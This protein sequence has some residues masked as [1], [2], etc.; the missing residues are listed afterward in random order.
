MQITSEQ[1]FSQ[2]SIEEDA[3]YQELMKCPFMQ[4]KY[5]DGPP[6]QEELEA[7]WA[8]AP[9]TVHSQVDGS[10]IKNPHNKQAPAPP[11]G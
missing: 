9:D 10:I 1:Q 11:L 7:L 2:I 3:K 5:K 6:P 4:M 8:Q